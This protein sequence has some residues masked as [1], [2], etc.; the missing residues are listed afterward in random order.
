LI[1]VAVEHG[2]G[3]QICFAPSGRRVAWPRLKNG[4]QLRA[5]PDCQ[6]PKRAQQRG[7]ASRSS[8][9]SDTD[10]RAE[11]LVAG[12]E[13]R[14]HVYG[15][16]VSSVVELGSNADV[17]DDGRPGLDPDTRAARLDCGGVSAV[18]KILAPCLNGDRAF[19]GALWMIPEVERCIEESMQAISDDLVDHTAVPDHDAG[20]ALEILVKRC[21]QLL[22]AGAMHRSGE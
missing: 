11:L 4:D 19:D 21:D 5:S 17:T 1:R 13:T 16:A 2:V 10:R 9:R 22:R 12:F 20:N 8:T 6:L 14:R 18:A 7:V 15:I 3:R